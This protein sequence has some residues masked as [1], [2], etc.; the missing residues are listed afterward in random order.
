MSSPKPASTTYPGWQ[1]WSLVPG[2]LGEA[3]ACLWPTEHPPCAVPLLPSTQA[4][5]NTAWPR[6]PSLQTGQCS[7]NEAIWL[8]MM[9]W[10]FPNKSS[11]VYF[12]RC[13]PSLSCHFRSVY[14]CSEDIVPQL[15]PPPDL[16]LLFF[17]LL[18]CTSYLRCQESSLTEFIVVIL[19]KLI[20]LS[21]RLLGSE[22]GM[23][24]IDFHLEGKVSSFHSHEAI[25][26]IYD[27]SRR[28]LARGNDI[29]VQLKHF[30][31][32][33]FSSILLPLI[34]ENNIQSNFIL[35][36]TFLT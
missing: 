18:L 17:P 12:G 15:L 31:V 22:A 26:K 23:R 29:P 11:A 35:H 33:F 4:S 2:P 30:Q 20:F 3:T 27:R 13:R 16:P 8:C 10:L 24:F 36:C 25:W 21:A 1:L 14:S 9:V 28:T 34:L 6:F 32:S 19:I 5:L 7:E